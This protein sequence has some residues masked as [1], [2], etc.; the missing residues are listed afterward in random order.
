MPQGVGPTAVRTEPDET[1]ETATR[2]RGASR[3]SH[4]IR[5]RW[6]T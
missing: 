5:G 4:S 6:N 2:R 1:P 3:R